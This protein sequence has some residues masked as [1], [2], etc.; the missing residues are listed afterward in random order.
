MLTHPDYRKSGP[1]VG[2]L[3]GTSV[4]IDGDTV[5]VG[6][7][8]DN[9][10]GTAHVWQRTGS[11]W[12][13][14]M[15][16]APT[17][18]D[19]NYGQNFGATVDISGDTIVIGA[20]SDSNSGGEYAGA[21]YVFTRSGSRAWWSLSQRLTLPDAM[22][23]DSFGKTV[24]V[25]GDVLTVS[26]AGRGSVFVY[27]KTGSTWSHEGTLSGDVE[28]RGGSFGSGTAIDGDDIFISAQSENHSEGSGRGYVYA[29]RWS[30]STWNQIAK[31]WHSGSD[32]DDGYGSQL[33][34]DGSKA[35]VSFQGGGVAGTVIYS[36]TGVT[37]V[38]SEVFTIDDTD[39]SIAGLEM[40][41]NFV[42]HGL[43]SDDTAGN[44]AGAAVV[45]DLM[46]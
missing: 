38:E 3:F 32:D 13:Y 30:G 14:V 42:I 4:A 2:D 19:N 36:W 1:R 28:G 39:S 8:N 43:G 18:N 40:S 35:V 10:K 6:S 12:S 34:V 26:S 5:V 25:D 22:H 27:R 15:L 45:Y 16:L 44:N 41:G 46:P 9:G 23:L 17:G 7:K 29:Y 20:G 37:W 11:S 31:L 33:A 21:A 24:S